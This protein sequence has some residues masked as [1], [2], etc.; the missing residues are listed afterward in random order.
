MMLELKSQH[1]AGP[2]SSNLETKATE[3]TGVKHEKNQGNPAKKYETYETYE[4][5][6]NER[7][8]SDRTQEVDCWEMMCFFLKGNILRFHVSFS[9][10]GTG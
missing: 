5:M 4:T 3:A 10:D 6:K 7:I 9:G 8:E 1:I 2:G